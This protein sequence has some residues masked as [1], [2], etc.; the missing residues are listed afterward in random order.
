[1]LGKASLVIDGANDVNGFESTFVG[2]GNKRI[3]CPVGKS[4][5]MSANIQSKI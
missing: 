1:M 4:L 3:E 2:Q 5:S